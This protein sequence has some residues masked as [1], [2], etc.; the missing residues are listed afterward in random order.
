[1]DY[2]GH[3]RFRPGEIWVVGAGFEPACSPTSCAGASASPAYGL[4]GHPAPAR[5]HR[6][7]QPKFKEHLPCRTLGKKVCSR[8]GGSGSSPRPAPIADCSGAVC[9]SVAA[10]LPKSATPIHLSTHPSPSPLGPWIVPPVRRARHPA[11]VRRFGQHR[12]AYLG[13]P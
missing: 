5:S 7:A 3:G 8:P 2:I 12:R 10:D 4:N 11:S 9:F 13:S 1:M 6:A